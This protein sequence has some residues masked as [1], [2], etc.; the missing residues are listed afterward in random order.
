MLS[1]CVALFTFVTL[2]ALCQDRPMYRDATRPIDERVSDL[3]SRMTLEEKVAQTLAVWKGKERITDE[4]GL[5]APDK[6]S[7][8]LANGIGQIARPSELRD[9]PSRI[10]LGPRE[11]A[12]FVNAV[13]KW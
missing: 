5:F 1:R 3:L 6:A 4:K 7:A 9:R 13:Q 8:L 2:P 12:V 10:V 11:N